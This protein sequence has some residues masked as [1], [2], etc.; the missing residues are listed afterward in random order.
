MT[1]SSGVNVATDQDGWTSPPPVQLADG[2]TIQLTKDGEAL[3]VAYQAIA[4]AKRRVCLETF[5]FHSDDTGRAFAELLSK[6][7]KEGLDVRVIYDSF[8]SGHTDPAMFDAMS[9]A[10]VRVRE[11]HPW[12]PWRCKHGW[13]IFNRDHRKQLIV[14][15]E[16]GVVGGQNLGDEYGGSWITGKPHDVWRDTGIGCRGPSVRLLSEAFTRMWYYI[17]NG[18]PITR[19]EFFHTRQSFSE[20]PGGSLFTKDQ[21][22]GR[23]AKPERLDAAASVL[24]APEDPFAALGS[25]PTPQSRF[26][27]NLQ[28][29][30]RDAESLI[31]MTMA[32]FAP[33][34]EL[35]ELLCKSAKSGVRVRLMF[36]GHSN[37]P[38]VLIAQRAFYKKLLMAGVEIYERERVMLHAKTLC[39]DGRISII[40]STNLDYRS[41][42]FNCELSAA[43]HSAPLGEQMHDLFEHDVRFARQIL[44]EEWRHRPLHD[45]FVQW[46]VMRARYLL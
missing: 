12:K 39:V 46:A 25:V 44:P 37:H 10:G 42:Q 20:D 38:I 29:L 31:E 35:V 1:Q 45:R 2:T 30:L 15:D 41:I 40:G 23:A 16:V 21:P 18:G 7:A 6:R 43:I 27:A 3:Y 24:D 22:E 19:A 28:K 33:P 26:V 14:D 5:I 13:R 36:P 4:A 17:E 9:A 8:G 11:F 34:E 32:Y